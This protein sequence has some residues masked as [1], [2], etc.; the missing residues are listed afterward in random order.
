MQEALVQS[1]QG[2]VAFARDVE[3]GNR[4]YASKCDALCMPAVPIVMHAPLALP[5]NACSVWAAVADLLM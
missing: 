5:Y 4:Q 2:A 3:F 1:L